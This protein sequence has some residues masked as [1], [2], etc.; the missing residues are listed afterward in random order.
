ME[1]IELPVLAKGDYKT[2]LSKMGYDLDKLVLFFESGEIRF[3]LDM[4]LPACR[5]THALELPDTDNEEW[6]EIVS[7]CT[8]LIHSWTT[9][10]L[11]STGRI[12]RL[13]IGWCGD[14]TAVKYIQLP[15]FTQAVVK[16]DPN[17]RTWYNVKVLLIGGKQ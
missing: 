8:Y 1:W 11:M 17:S 14:E 15:Q 2:T 6:K 13:P 5:F 12:Q 16:D 4:D 9:L 3:V 7:G 10:V